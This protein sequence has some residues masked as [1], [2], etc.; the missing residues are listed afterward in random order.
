MEI[1]NVPLLLDRTVRAIS[2][3]GLMCGVSGQGRQHRAFGDGK[4]CFRPIFKTLG[5]TER[6]VPVLCL[7]PWKS[8]ALQECQT[9]HL[10]VSA[11]L[12]LCCQGFQYKM[13]L[14]RASNL[15]KNLFQTLPP[16]EREK[17]K[18]RKRSKKHHISLPSPSPSPLPSS[19]P[20]S[21]SAESCLYAVS[22]VVS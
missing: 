22:A 18:K 20:W 1:V 5:C 2:V 11:A 3:H 19:A 14:F 4:F 21:V 16:L 13:K 7:E 6:S 12:P 10:G 9:P 8:P 15:V 17:K